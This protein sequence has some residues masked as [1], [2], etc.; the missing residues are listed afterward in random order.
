MRHLLFAERLCSNALCR[1]LSD[2]VGF[3]TFASL[4]LTLYNVVN[5]KFEYRNS[6]QTLNHQKTHQRCHP[7]LGSGSHEMLK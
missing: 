7:E 1:F 3:S 4:L 2:D 6:K 5:S